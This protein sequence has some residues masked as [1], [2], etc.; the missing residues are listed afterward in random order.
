MGVL[1]PMQSMDQQRSVACV[2]VQLGTGCVWLPWQCR[3][4][5]VC[6]A[7]SEEGGLRGVGGALCVVS[8]MHQCSDGNNT[9]MIT[10]APTLA[11]G[12]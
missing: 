2:V 8:P 1:I 4:G 10:A 9:V 3:P 12:V 7:H 6:A 11:Q 5:V